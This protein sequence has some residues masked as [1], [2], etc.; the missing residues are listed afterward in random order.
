[1]DVPADAQIEWTYQD[2][3][4]STETTFDYDF[5]EFGTFEVTARLTGEDCIES[6]A[7][8][9]LINPDELLFQDT[10][11]Q[12]EPGNIVLNPDGDT[13]LIYTWT[14]PNLESNDIA[15]PTASVEMNSIY[16][17]IIQHPDDTTCQ[18]TGRVYVFIETASDIIS[19]DKTEFCMGDTARLTVGNGGESMNIQW[20]DPDGVLIGSQ[21]TVEFVFEK[22]GEYTVI[23]DINGC[24]FMDTIDLQFRNAEIVASQTEGIC[25]G[26][27]VMLEIQ[28]N[29]EEAYDSIVWGPED[30]VVSDTDP[31]MATYSPDSNSIV[32]VWVYFPDGCLSMDT[33]MLRIPP[34]LADLTISSD[35]DTV[36]RG[37]KA[38]LTASDNGFVTYRWE[39]ADFVDNPD[40]PQTEVIPET[41]TTF[42][43]TATDANGCA[44]IKTIT[45]VVLNPQCEPPYI[46]VPRAFS[47]NGDGTNDIL[48]VRGESIDEVQFI[49]YDRWGEKMFETNN[50]DR[51]WDGTFQGKQLPPDVYG[52]Y[53]SVICIGGDTYTEK[54]NVTIIR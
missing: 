44:V 53:L 21:E 2:S 22:M 51:G 31:A 47:P 4:I 46:F 15:S 13:T 30:V 11:Y 29:T 50:L 12:C 39:P 5:G 24:T 42:T 19:T 6:S 1:V 20:S 14:G 8:I 35:R 33:V 40:Q 9:T 17:A 28:F 26:D 41:T 27:E 36:I 38:T 34:A 49:V 23:A 45:I 16:N 48:Y 43:L 25:P 7:L 10:I 18:T 37:Q 3:I 52:Y 32:T 54:G